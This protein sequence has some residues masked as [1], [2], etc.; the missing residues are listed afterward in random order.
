[1]KKCPKCGKQ[2]DDVSTICLGPFCSHA[3]L[4]EVNVAINIPQQQP[5]SEKNSQKIPDAQ[6][7]RTKKC[8]YCAEEIKKEAL[9][10]FH[11]KER[12]YEKRG[13]GKIGGA[14][15]LLILFLMLLPDIY[16]IL[17]PFASFLIFI[18]A[19]IIGSLFFSGLAE[20]MS[21]QKLKEESKEP[22]KPIV[23]KSIKILGIAVL[24]V[25]ALIIAF[26]MLVGIIFH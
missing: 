11:C 7:I 4:I 22:K 19:I 2:Y 10:C 3:E 5:L 8:P 15:L 13:S 20:Q 16:A 18:I 12:I 21:V 1:M 25:M 6:Q 26:L 24:S 14:I 17:G 23:R 9:I